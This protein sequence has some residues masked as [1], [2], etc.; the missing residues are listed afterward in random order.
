MSGNVK[1]TIREIEAGKEFEP[2]GMALSRWE[3]EIVQSYIAHWRRSCPTELANQLRSLDR[4]WRS[5]RHMRR[6]CAVA[7]IL[8]D[9]LDQDWLV[10]AEK[11]DIYVVP[12][13][14]RTDVEFDPRKHKERLRRS[15]R[16]GR[17]KQVQEPSVRSFLN[18]MER[19][20]VLSLI[21]SGADLLKELQARPHTVESLAEVI[22]PEVV[23]CARD[24]TDDVTG[25]N[26]LDVWRYFRHTWSLEYRP[27]P[28]RTMPIIIRNRARPNR[29][30]IGIALLASPVMRLLQRD[31]WFGW[32]ADALR[33]GRQDETQSVKQW[34]AQAMAVLENAI[35]GIRYDDLISAEAVKKPTKDDIILLER[36]AA[37]A[38]ALRARLLE[39]VHSGEE[40]TYLTRGAVKE[41]LPETDWLEA[42]SDPLFI[43]KR[44]EVLVSLLDAKR[45]LMSVSRKK[46]SREALLEFLDKRE[47]DRFLTTIARERLKLAVSSQLMDVAICG[48]IPPYN[49]LI[50]GKLVTLL[51]TS[52]EIQN[53][54]RTRYGGQ[55]SIIASQM[56]GRPVVKEAEL[57]CLTT[58]SL[59]GN[60]GSSQ[61]N[62]LRLS[63][64]DHP[65]LSNDISWQRI[66]KT[67][68]FGS[69]H[70]SNATVECLRD[71]SV[72]FHGARRIN[73]RFGEGTNPRMRQ[74]REGLEALGIESD[75]VLAHSTPRILYGCKLTGTNSAKAISKAWIRRWL[76]GRV[77]RDDLAARLLPLG[78][79]SVSDE[80][81]SDGEG[82]FVL[83]LE[84][85]TVHSRSSSASAGTH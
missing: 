30:V 72:D 58:S 36:K 61:Y 82:Q 10:T 35:S 24:V 15:L 44:A 21:D 28:G 60:A 49:Q 48:A 19:G 59:Y 74:I 16:K 53:A 45:S 17:D 31:A 13:E 3:K 32:S 42:S 55:A 77:G 85:G 65:E 23:V 11:G 22:D 47:G 54:Y 66:G 4:K 75:R 79:K 29:P 43:K 14:L 2:L 73:S 80:L 51:L 76:I 56:A 1:E 37:G 57:T 67:R 50:G 64:E 78:P 83:P 46:L 8:A 6:V 70:L 12:S 41:A 38:D 9:L 84:D 62:R 26:S 71:A 7:L 18:S 63:G 52:K 20:G 34:L 69:V 40:S 5:T 33:Q 68:G 39:E 81:A 27:T 25:L